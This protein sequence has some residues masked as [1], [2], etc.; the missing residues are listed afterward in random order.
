MEIQL[1]CL[2]PYRYTAKNKI[3]MSLHLHHVPQVDMLECRLEI[4]QIIPHPNKSAHLNMQPQ[5]KGVSITTYCQMTHIL[6]LLWK[7]YTT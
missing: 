5:I 6:W 7:D 1:Q 3:A 2:Q 4:L